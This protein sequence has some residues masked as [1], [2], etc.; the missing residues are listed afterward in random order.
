MIYFKYI[1]LIKFLLLLNS[2][3]GQTS[4]PDEFLN[5]NNISINSYK[6]D[7]R[8]LAGATIKYNDSVNKFRKPKPKSEILNVEIDTV[9][10]GP[11]GKLTFLSIFKRR[12]PYVQSLKM[13]GNEEG[14]EFKG[15]CYLAVKDT[16]SN[17]IQIVK[18]LKYSAGSNELD[19]YKRVKNK[20]REI[21]LREMDYIDGRYNINDTRFWNSNVWD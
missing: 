18:K 12:N 13:K 8:H 17:N 14:I 10:Y 6:D 16:V 3:Q 19:A 21:Y 11:K 15:R 1:I 20:L 7:I 9:F 4:T 5:K 2:C